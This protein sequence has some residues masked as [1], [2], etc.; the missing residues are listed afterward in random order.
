MVDVPLRDDRKSDSVDDELAG[1]LTAEPP[2]SFFLFAGAGSGKTRA[3]V[4]TLS[5]LRDIRSNDLRL[6]GQQIGVITYTNAACDEIKR[7]LDFDPLVA[8][9]TI[10]SFVWELIKGFD[11]DIRSWLKRNLRA[12]IDELKE[13]LR[14]GRSGTKVAGQRE[15]SIIAKS[16]RLDGLDTIKRFIYSPTSD[17]RTRDSLNHA[18]VIKMATDFILTKPLMQRLLIGAFPLLLIDESQDTNKLLIDALMT[19]QEHHRKDFGLGLFG[20]TMQ[21]IYADGKADLGQHLPADWS[22][23]AITTNYRCPRRIIRLINKIRSEADGQSQESKSDATEG[24][25]RLFIAP[26][27]LTD[28]AHTEDVVRKRMA[29]ATGD[30]QW[31]QPQEV[32]T[33]TLEHHM[34]AKRMRFFEMFEPLYKVDRFRTGLLDGSLP[35]VKLFSSVILPLVLAKQEKNEF[36]VAAIVRKHSPLLSKEAVTAKKDNQLSQ[37]QCAKVAVEELMSLWKNGSEPRFIEVLNCVSRGRLFE[38]PDALRAFARSDDEDEPQTDAAAD[39]ENPSGDKDELQ[40][41]EDDDLSAIGDFL[42][43]SFLQIQPYAAYVDGKAHFGTHQGV[44]GLEFP[45]VLVIADDED[46]RGFMFSYDKLFG[47]KE[48][49]AADA[50]HEREGEETGND[51]TRRLFYVTCS[52]SKESLAIIAYTTN[53]SKVQQYAIQRGWFDSSEIEMLSE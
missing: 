19:I 16:E 33:L 21:R 9:S 51:R 7:R 10:H 31:E 35:I 53:P 22:R 6:H 40:E 14:K 30:L 52:R 38:I 41:N 15:R 45:R 49:T 18:E 4:K 36:A 44:K 2:R 34:A 3:L 50:K 37:V 48:Q 29:K 17:N 28:K 23:P 26:T 24:Y 11:L 39:A 42:N 5:R 8:V 43:T 12:E 1:C 27:G 20:D 13:L 47:A 46:A 25:A 32:K